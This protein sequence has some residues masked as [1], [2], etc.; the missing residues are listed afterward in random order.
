MDISWLIDFLVD[1]FGT[2]TYSPCG[3]FLYLDILIFGWIYLVVLYCRSSTDPSLP[4]VTRWMYCSR[5]G[6]RKHTLNHAAFTAPTHEQ[7]AQIQ[8]F[9]YRYRVDHEYTAVSSICPEI[10]TA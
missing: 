7:M 10:S 1:L 9:V 2:F 6:L 3:F 8:Q 4:T 5:A